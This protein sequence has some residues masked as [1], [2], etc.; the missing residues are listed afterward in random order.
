M[1]IRLTFTIQSANTTNDILSFDVSA[2]SGTT[3]IGKSISD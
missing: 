1:S 2:T 3:A